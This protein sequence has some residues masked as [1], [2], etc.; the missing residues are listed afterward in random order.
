MTKSFPIVPKMETV[1]NVGHFTQVNLVYIWAL[2]S[3][4]FVKL[5]L[6]R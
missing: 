1:K 3:K 6:R 5:W 4:P 2:A